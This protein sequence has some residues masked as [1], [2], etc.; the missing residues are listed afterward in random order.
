[1]T[2]AVLP[3]ELVKKANDATAAPLVFVNPDLMDR[4]LRTVNDEDSYESDETR[5]A[6]KLVTWVAILLGYRLKH[7]G[8]I[9]VYPHFGD[10]NVVWRNKKKCARVK[11]TFT[12]NG[13][14]RVYAEQMLLGKVSDNHL[15]ANATIG[16][17]DKSL[18][19]LY[20]A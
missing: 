8:E 3:E 1:M 5:P 4:F 18:G 19:W 11:A 16:D 10:I 13:T 12:A 9:E 2:T 20:S 6:N 14:I 17:L 7:R 15:I